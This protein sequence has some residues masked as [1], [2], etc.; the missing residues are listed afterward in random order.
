MKQEVH[1]KILTGAKLK[2]VDKYGE[3]IFST[4]D[5]M[6][7][8]PPNMLV[9]I[10]N[11]DVYATGK[12]VRFTKNGKDKYQWVEDVEE[13]PIEKAQQPVKQKGLS[14]GLTVGKSFVRKFIR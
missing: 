6:W 5:G 14:R 10:S 4:D 11:R 9:G 8:I 12:L 3:F 1:P 2:K 7:K 13:K